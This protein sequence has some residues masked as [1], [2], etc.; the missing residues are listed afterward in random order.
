MLVHQRETGW[1]CNNHLEKYMSKSMGRISPYIMEHKNMFE[2][3]N[4]N[5]ICIMM[6]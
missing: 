4:K 5:K 6:S 3:T 2:T 1:W